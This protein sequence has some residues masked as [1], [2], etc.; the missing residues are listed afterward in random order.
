[1]AAVFRFGGRACLAGGNPGLAGGQT[2]CGNAADVASLF[3]ALKV[4]SLKSTPGRVL[5]L[6]VVKNATVIIW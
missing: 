1:M 2:G 5:Q 3:G 6:V 4:K